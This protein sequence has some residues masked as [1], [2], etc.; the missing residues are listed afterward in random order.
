MYVTVTRVKIGSSL[1]KN[2]EL[3]AE[4]RVMQVASQ[5]DYV[6]LVFTNTPGTNTFSGA[7]TLAAS[8]VAVL[9]FALATL[10]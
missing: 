1:K 2:S 7:H 9:A 8:L 5:A 3:V 4:S 10:F 6:S